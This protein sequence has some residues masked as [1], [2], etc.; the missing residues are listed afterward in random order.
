LR[1]IGLADPLLSRALFLVNVARHFGTPECRQAV[2]DLGELGIHDRRVLSALIEATTSRADPET[3]GTAVRSLVALGGRAVPL[4]A[5]AL[6]PAEDLSR[7]HLLTALRRIGP[8][9]A[10]AAP[11]VIALLE[12]KHGPLDETTW[13]STVQERALTTLAAFGPAAEPAVEILRKLLSDDERRLRTLAA[14]VLAKIGSRKSITALRQALR[15]PETQKDAAGGIVWAKFGERPGQIRGL[16]KKIGVA[17]ALSGIVKTLEGDNSTTRNIT[18]AAIELLGEVGPDAAAALPAL[19][20]IRK[21]VSDQASVDTAI[22]RI[23]RPRGT[24][25]AAPRRKEKPARRQPTT[26]K[27]RPGSL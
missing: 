13:H 22:G 10:P 2:K 18:D 8:D 5:A 1:T 17:I 14:L 11:Q 16:V 27:G 20:S 7:Q 26:G 23:Q 9:A 3:N 25:P 6:Q 21:E 12:E 24:Q 4:V 15:D 19:K